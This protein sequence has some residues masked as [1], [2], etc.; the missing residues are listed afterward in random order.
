MG[1]KLVYRS[2]RKMAKWALDGFYSEVYVS[3][4]E[5]VPTTGPVLMYVHPVCKHPWL[6]GTIH[7]TASHHNELLD[8]A[9]IGQ[10]LLFLRHLE[11]YSVT[12]SRQHA[13]K[14]TCML[15]GKVQH[16]HEPDPQSH[17]DVCREH[18]CA[19]QPQRPLARG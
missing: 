14:K 5:N 3:G 10:Y 18:P 11:I 7:S 9:S 17:H 2:L 6:T 15:L 4:Q 16:V 12:I 19:A 8:V 1:Y 13:W